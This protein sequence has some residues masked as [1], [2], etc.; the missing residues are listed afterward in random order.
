MIKINLPRALASL[1]VIRLA[2]ALYYTVIAD[3]DE[4]FN[5]WEP[6]HFLTFG[7]G[8]ET[9]EYSPQFNIRSW[10]YAGLHGVTSFALSLLGL[11]KTHVF[12]AIRSIFAIISAFVEARLFERVK[13]VHG[14]GVANWLLLFLMAST[15]MTAASTA[16]LPSTF[17]M[18]LVTAAFSYSLS[19]T[20]SS[21]RTASFVFLI[22]SSV[23]VGWPF[24][25]AVAIPFLVE[26]LVI[27]SGTG[28]MKRWAAA[29]R[30]GLAAFAILLVPTTFVD[31]IY[32]GFW[33]IV[34]LKIVL[35]N[36]FSGSGEGKG[37]DIFGTEPWWF[38]LVNGFLNFNIVFLAA[39]V[40]IFTVILSRFIMGA[41]KTTQTLSL[42]Q[43]IN[44]LA[45]FY[46]WL[47]IFT[48]QPHKE[49]RFLFVV[50]PILCYN[51]S[52]AVNA[53]V[54]TITYMLAPKTKSKLRNPNK[55]SLITTILQYGIA[56]LFVILSFSRTMAM[57]TNY[58]APIAIFTA[59]Q[60]HLSS[61]DRLC[62]GKEWHR[63]PSHYFIPNGVEVRWIRS[64][65]RGLLPARFGDSM[66]PGDWARWEVTRVIPDGL[67]EY[68]KEDSS[69]YVNTD[70]CDYLVDSLFGDATVGGNADEPRFVE[71]TENWDVV[72]CV[73]FLDA[74]RSRGVAG[75]VF[76]VPEGLY[77][78]GRVWGRYCLLK[79]KQY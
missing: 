21:A 71:D 31:R 16:F 30:A 66:A 40:S 39:L 41:P 3:C 73:R 54:T 42:A 59:A 47:A 14:S 50:Y 57:L 17:S 19:P 2:S 76:W 48:A 38:Y 58:S 4:V 44:R 20:P 67:N 18:Y 78:K 36:V 61:S 63:F 27:V 26:D 1:V 6:A 13:D 5:Y 12:F 8:F 68:N 46:V 35:Y 77:K 72:A 10:F 9:W 11:K 32:Y 37:P 62:V 64:A 24:S 49:E 70:E 22:A 45:P 34:P 25:G 53:L 15:G 23:I 56:F 79:K 69:R 55:K 60:S 28:I 75:K 52:I 51:A 29:L 74:G 7:A 65:F 33:S 43:Q